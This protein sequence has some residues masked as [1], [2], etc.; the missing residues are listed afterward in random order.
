MAKL[1]V[2][3]DTLQI[4]RFRLLRGLTP[5]T[6]TGFISRGEAPN[7]T[8]GSDSDPERIRSL[9]QP[10]AFARSGH[11]AADGFERRFPVSKDETL[12]FDR[13]RARSGE[14]WHRP[15]RPRHK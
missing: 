14:K 2:R 13:E 12:S 8:G 6:G 1:N 9:G 15:S 11:S 4:P 3:T 7:R 10:S 5:E